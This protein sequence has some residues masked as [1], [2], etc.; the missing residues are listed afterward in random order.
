[1]DIAVTC[2]WWTCGT[3]RGG[4][5]N[6]T[7]RVVES[8]R[9]STIPSSHGFT[10]PITSTLFPPNDPPSDFAAAFS[11]LCKTV[12][13]LIRDCSRSIAAARTA[14]CSAQPLSQ[15]SLQACPAVLA[16][17]S[18]PPGFSSIYHLGPSRPWPHDARSASLAR[19][20]PHRRCGCHNTQSHRTV[21]GCNNVAHGIAYANSDRSDVGMVVGGAAQAKASAMGF[22]T[23]LGQCVY[24]ETK[25]TGAGAFRLM[26]VGR[27]AVPS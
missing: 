18:Y 7:T 9:A 15:S 16:A 12:H 1:M 22:P 4:R 14:L 20:A 19:P 6:D 10:E 2:S 3:C 26:G 27:I 11:P 17:R 24:F 5:T 21:H 13:E 23:M 25:C 8:P